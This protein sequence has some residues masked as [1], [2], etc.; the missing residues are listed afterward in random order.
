MPAR[1]E[2]NQA[3]RIRLAIGHPFPYDLIVRTPEHLRR[4]VAE[5]DSFVAEIVTRGRVLYEKT[6]PT[7]HPPSTRTER[8]GKEKMILS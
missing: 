4:R 5:G 3:V 7:G 6:G 8:S 2:I 1:N